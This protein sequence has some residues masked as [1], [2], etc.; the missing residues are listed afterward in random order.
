ML[1]FLIVTSDHFD[2]EVLTPEAYRHLTLNMSTEDFEQHRCTELYADVEVLFSLTVY[3]WNID[4]ETGELVPL[5]AV[6]YGYQLA[7]AG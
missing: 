5:D 6:D 7:I 2:N 3:V 4:R 1:K